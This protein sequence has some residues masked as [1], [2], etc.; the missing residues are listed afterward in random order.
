MTHKRSCHKGLY[1]VPLW[2]IV[3]SLVAI[4]AGGLILYI[5]PPCLILSV[6]GVPCPTCGMTRAWLAALHLDFKTA[7][8]MHP[9]FWSIPILG[10][11]IL[12]DCRLLKNKILNWLLFGLILLGFGVN[13]IVT[14]MEW[15]HLI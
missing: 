15:F 7:F 8:A 2:K 4:A 13:Y 1:S 6:F 3:I 10:V 11:Y 14:L 9:L 5:G 12:R